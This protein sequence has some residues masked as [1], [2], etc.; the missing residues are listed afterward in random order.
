[1][2]SSTHQLT[3]TLWRLSSTA[4]AFVMEMIAPW[5]REGHITRLSR[6]EADGTD[7]LTHLGGHVW[8]G[9]LLT[10]GAHQTGDVDDVS[11]MPAEVWQ[12]VLQRE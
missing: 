11:L 6:S 9:V 7:A 4:I 3:L 2:T 10:D 12:R 8:S 5:W 1:M